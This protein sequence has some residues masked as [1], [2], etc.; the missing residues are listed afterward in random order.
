MTD[1]YILD[2]HTP[3][4]EPDLMKWAEWLE[5]AERHVAQDEKGGVRVSTVFL[6]LD[7]S[8]YMSKG[9]APILFETMVFGDNSDERMERYATWEEAEKGHA[10]FVK[11]YLSPDTDE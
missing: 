3:V 10:R 5:T 4:P 9:N 1:R 8:F 7:Y 2:G 6:G 11:K